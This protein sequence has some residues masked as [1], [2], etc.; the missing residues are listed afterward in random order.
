MSSPP[1][2][3]RAAFR[4][5]K[6]ES[7]GTAAASRQERKADKKKK[8]HLRPLDDVL[9]EVESLMAREGRRMMH[10]VE[11]IWRVAGITDQHYLDKSIEYSA[12][13]DMLD[14]RLLN[15]VLPGLGVPMPM[16]QEDQEAGHGAQE[17]LPLSQTEIEARIMLV[18]QCYMSD[19]LVSVA[20]LGALLVA[21]TIKL[22]GFPVNGLDTE[23]IS[24]L[25][26]PS[27]KG[28]ARSMVPSRIHE[29]MLGRVV[30]VDVSKLP[31][32]WAAW[33]GG[34]RGDEERQVMRETAEY[35]LGSG[36]QHIVTCGK[37][38]EA[39]VKAVAIHHQHSRP[40]VNRLHHLVHPVVLLIEWVGHQP[41]V[42]SWGQQYE[43]VAKLIKGIRG[44]DR[45]E[46][47]L[48]LQY[49]DA[50][51]K[52]HDAE[53]KG[54]GRFDV[55]RAVKISRALEI[56]SKARIRW[57]QLPPLVKTEVTLRTGATNDAE[58]D[59]WVRK[60]GWGP[61]QRS[62][63]EPRLTP[64]CFYLSVKGIEGGKK[65][66]KKGGKRGGRSLFALMLALKVAR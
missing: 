5:P 43:K 18:R 51:A 17:L 38:G 25:L 60:E 44:G 57:D 19:T 8:E 37:M 1:S 21:D 46:P 48:L 50:V 66:G 61:Q 53:G 64:D 52:G 9:P 4:T 3:A 6:H 65:G 11:E 15:K 41:T 54:V 58:F 10:S 27:G 12:M 29:R 36:F 23:F 42:M 35:A 13:V 2:L 16:P 49:L 31:G 28:F 14:E 33:D 62:T 26:D 59:A 40:D 22:E 63:P 34:A 20:E 30:R 39:T 56:E 45:D 47:G 55:A 24:P 7:K 32:H